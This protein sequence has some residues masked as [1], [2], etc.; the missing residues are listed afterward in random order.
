M[1]HIEKK[2]TPDEAYKVLR[3]SSGREAQVQ[4]LNESQL[5]QPM[6]ERKKADLEVRMLRV[7]LVR[8]TNHV[9]RN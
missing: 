5:L 2:A 4:M 3:G 9:M 7:G 6:N 8:S 1:K